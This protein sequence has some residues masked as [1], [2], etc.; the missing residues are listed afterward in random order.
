MAVEFTGRGDC[1]VCVIYLVYR[2]SAYIGTSVFHMK[3]C[4]NPFEDVRVIQ[5]IAP[6]KFITT[7]VSVML[8]I[9]SAKCANELINLKNL[10]PNVVYEL[11]YVAESCFGCSLFSL[12][13]IFTANK[14]KYILQH[15]DLLLQLSVSRY[16]CC[17]SNIGG[18]GSFMIT[19]KKY[20]GFLT[21]Q[22]IYTIL[23]RTLLVK[24]TEWWILNTITM[25]I[26]FS[27]Y[28]IIV[29]ILYLLCEILIEILL[30]QNAYVENGLELAEAN[31]N[32]GNDFQPETMATFYVDLHGDIMALLNINFINLLIAFITATCAVI[33]DIFMLIA[34]QWTEGHI[35][36]ILSI[37]E[38]T[39]LACV[40]IR[41]G[42]KL[43]NAVS[44]LVCHFSR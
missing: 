37:A 44:I 31:V 35:F 17:V 10:N 6:F 14:T 21:V 1:I 23:T 8:L 32:C 16:G 40:G 36:C 11:L 41:I 12:T 3:C 42:D 20:H 13:V 33:L 2:V 30:S 7:F 4:H 27:M 26:V 24:N 43:R 28:V 18:F 5:P 9:C 29:M 34:I 25:S 39:I 22:V 19:S 15:I 38:I